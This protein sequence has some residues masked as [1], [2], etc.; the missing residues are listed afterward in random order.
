MGKKI[1]NE[2]G[3]NFKYYY[4]SYYT[5]YKGYDISIRYD[6]A[7][8]LYNMYF[9]VKGSENIDKL[10]E[11]LSKIDKYAI[12]KYKNNLLTITEA[13][14]HSRDIPLLANKIIDAVIKY[15]DT[16]KYKNI[17]KMCNKSNKTKLISIDDNISFLCDDCIKNIN[18]SYK[19]E[20]E[21]K[22]KIKENIFLGI[23]GSILGC[24][25]GL[26]IWMVLVYLMIN[27]TVIGLIIMFGS[28]YFYKYMANS[29]KLP[30]LILSVIIG[31]LFILLANEFTNAFNLYNE[32]INQY[33]INIFDAYKAIPYYVENSDAFRISYDQ[34][35][36]LALMFA[37]F[38]S[39]TN[40]GLY[41]RY[42]ASNKIKYMEVK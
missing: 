39:F 35:L 13:C 23:I 38:G 2:L 41:R 20:Y 37:V 19:K 22:K 34:N 17:C 31:L 28:A 12:A 6:Y 25:P 15:L 33:N 30:G 21:E 24:I 11:E 42:I 16:K 27:P 10:N 3:H 1:A 26:I 9:N 14:D 5:N 18:K 40:I 29:L 7:S 36:I 32:Y 8:L 4:G